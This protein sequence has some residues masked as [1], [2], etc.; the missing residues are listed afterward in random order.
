MIYENDSN[1]IILY[2]VSHGYQSLFI[3]KIKY[4][5]TYAH[6]YSYICMCK[7]YCLQLPYSAKWWRGK[8]LVNLV[9]QT[10]FANILPSQIPDPLE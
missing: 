1:K 5:V 6:I 10:S 4:F 9:K 3:L 2:S 7:Q 8:T